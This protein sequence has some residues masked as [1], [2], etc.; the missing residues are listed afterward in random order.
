MELFFY[1]VKV[2]GLQ[3]LFLG[4]YF[5]ILKNLTFFT[6]NRIYL[7]SGLGG[8]Y[9]LPLFYFRKTVWVNP[10]PFSNN[11][12]YFSTAVSETS[13]NYW[14]LENILSTIYF[15]VF[16]FLFIRFLFQVSVLLKPIINKEYITYEGLKIIDHPHYGNPFSFLGFV[17]LHKATL[18]DK[19]LPHI[20]KHEAVHLRQYHS[21]DLLIAQ[22]STLVLWWNPLSYLYQKMISQNLE[23]IADAEATEQ[24]ADKK[25]Y[26][27]TM[28]YLGTSAVLPCINPFYQSSIKN[29]IAMMHQNPSSRYNRIKYAVVLPLIAFFVWQFQVKVIAQ[30]RKPGNEAY[31]PN[32]TEI[33]TVIY[34]SSPDDIIEKKIR[35]V[36]ITTGEKISWKG[37][38]NS[39]G[40]LNNLSIS[41]TKTNGEKGGLAIDTKTDTILPIK[42]SAQKNADGRYD[43]KVLPTLKGLI[44]SK[45]K[46]KD[47]VGFVLEELKVNDTVVNVL[48]NDEPATFPVKMRNATIDTL[49]K[50]DDEYTLKIKGKAH[51]IAQDT[52]KIK[53]LIIIDGKPYPG[54]ME[55][56]KLDKIL[57]PE[58]IESMTVLK[59]EQAIAKYGD[60]ARGGAIEII[61]KEIPRESIEQL[62]QHIA[63][64]ENSQL[65]NEAFYMLNGNK[66]SKAEIMKLDVKKINKINILQGKAATEK[67]GSLG[68]NGVIEVWT[69]PF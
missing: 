25:T 11:Y 32:I 40:F 8:S 10:K 19:T 48:V 52:S 69:R 68:T 57:N 15:S 67:Y 59:G 9:L 1:L 46:S 56:E 16:I 47:T 7:A 44:E 54:K 49:V 14:S 62:E 22:L 51:S 35:F 53:P 37:Y 28:L 27:K 29:R 17:Y 34:A 2:S 64:I 55:P 12:A 65:P 24:L 43:L 66:S 3:L 41:F 60:A 26:Q 61:T 58:A 33:S 23:Y 20:L 4:V 45:K 38:R 36:E 6:G 50:T 30:E 63:L 5:I 31:T 42:L 18:S 39:K 21:A 13:I